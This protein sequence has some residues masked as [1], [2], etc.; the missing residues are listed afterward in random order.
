MALS[1]AIKKSILM[2]SKDLNEMHDRAVLNVK[3]NFSLES[4]CKKTLEVY[5]RLL[6]SKW[7]S[8]HDLY[9]KQS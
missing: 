8:W 9:R 6:I 4:M 5:N 7:I 1:E 3:N 2:D